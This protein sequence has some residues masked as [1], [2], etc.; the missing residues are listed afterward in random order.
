[1]HQSHHSLLHSCEFVAAVRDGHCATGT[2]VC[3]SMKWNRTEKWVK[4]LVI[5]F[6]VLRI[7]NE[8]ERLAKFPTF[9]AKT[10]CTRDTRNI[11]FEQ[12]QNGCVLKDPLSAFVCFFQHDS[13][14]ILSEIWLWEVRKVLDKLECFPGVE[15]LVEK[16]WF[17]P[18]YGVSVGCSLRVSTVKPNAHLRRVSL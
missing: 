1:M 11:S 6:I 10:L 16:Y 18:K 12:F 17:P 13:G 7:Q 8:C 9:G 2:G 3:E 5:F 15:T 14:I 4:C